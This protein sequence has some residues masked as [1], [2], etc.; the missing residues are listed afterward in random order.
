[1]NIKFDRR[2]VSRSGR[3]VKANLVYMMMTS[4]ALF[5]TTNQKMAAGSENARNIQ[6]NRIIIPI[7]ELVGLVSQTKESSRGDRKRNLQKKQKVSLPKTT[8]HS[9]RSREQTH[10]A[11]HTSFCTN[12]TKRHARTGGAGGSECGRLAI[13]NNNS[14]EKKILANHIALC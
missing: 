6:P 3:G 14:I 1:M 8:F 9:K 4:L 2:R 7:L 11:N 12:D 5:R 13:W 10:E